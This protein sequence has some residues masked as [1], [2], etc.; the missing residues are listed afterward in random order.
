M[1][2]IYITFNTFLIFSLLTLLHCDNH[3]LTEFEKLPPE[4]QSGKSTFG[5]LVDGKAWVIEDIGDVSAFYQ[6][7]TFEVGA[8]VINKSFNSVMSVHITD[9]A[10]STK[11]YQLTKADIP[12]SSGASY[13][14]HRTSCE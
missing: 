4:T 3:E 12:L 6:T 14:D 13:Y 8:G 5:C 10:M 2:L 9:L 1:K 11:T 7:G